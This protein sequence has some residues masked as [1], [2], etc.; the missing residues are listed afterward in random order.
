MRI[1]KPS[2]MHFAT[3]E[4]PLPKMPTVDEAK[5]DYDGMIAR[6]RR[7]FETHTVAYCQ[8]SDLTCK[9]ARK[10]DHLSDHAPFEPPLGAMFEGSENVKCCLT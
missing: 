5:K 7:M 4:L 8:L 2:L 3:T 1:T 10:G 6:Y 9:E